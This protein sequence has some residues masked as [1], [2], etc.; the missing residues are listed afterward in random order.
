MIQIDNLPDFNLAEEELV[1]VQAIADAQMTAAQ[2]FT[3]LAIRFFMNLVVCS[4]LVGVFYYRKS[5]K[6][7]YFFTFMVF[8]SAMLL[9]LYVMG[10][11]EVGVGLTLGL[12]AIFGV[13]RYR[14]E[15]VPIRE[16]TYLFVII[17]L[18]AVNGLAP[19]YKLAGA[20][21]NA[22]HYELNTGALAVTALANA[23]VV[24]L[25][26]V[27]ESEKLLRHTSA[28]L[29]LYDRIELI[30]P[31]RRAELIAD[32]EKRVGVKVDN[33]EIGHVDFLRDA[34]YI[35]VYY[36]LEKGQRASID[37]LTK[38]RNFVPAFLLLLAL[39]VGL[40]AQGTASELESDLRA[41]LGV[42]VDHKISKGFH[43]N[44]EGEL[45]MK[46]G[47]LGRYQAGAG[48]SY[49]L[50]PYFKV[51][52]GCLFINNKN[53]SDEWK[54]RYRVY[55]DLT[56]TYRSGDWRFA[57]RERLQM[58]HRDVG[59]KTQTTP[60]ALALKS[61]F[62]VSYKG[63]RSVEP[64]ALAELRL[65]LNDP[66]CTATWNGGSY[67]DY[68]F[69]GYDDVYLNR[70]RGGFGLEWNLDR[71]NAIDI[72]GLLDYCYDKNIDTDK[73]RTILKSLTYDRTLSGIL[74]VGYKL[75]F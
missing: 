12:F 7:D 24:V 59:N 49:K 18:A 58:T 57:L 61:R 32:L 70:Y 21:G 5:R 46:D 38:A 42:K 56:G 36:T 40:K 52:A 65:A 23:L 41:R 63:F 19:I 72:Y 71:Q 53:S 73:T 20:T 27:L 9:L 22:P 33:I 67:T 29:V 11:V 37:T 30:V 15:T 2:S 16:M 64:Y 48:L 26:W 74:G 50:S 69:G 3:E 44:A 13:I 6:R 68:T 31:E 66:S 14:T 45:R 62:K 10:N 28:K 8:S 60:N 54:Q 4:V 75:S 34:A 17:A 43:L 55:V 51:G 25:V 35:K 1:N 39:P 47:Q